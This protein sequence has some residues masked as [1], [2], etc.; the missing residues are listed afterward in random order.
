M[1]LSVEIS[2]PQRKKD[3]T[4]VNANAKEVYVA[5]L[6]RSVNEADLRKLFEQ[7]GVRFRGLPD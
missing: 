4:D 1:R 2:D 7:V 5:G 6:A 3:R